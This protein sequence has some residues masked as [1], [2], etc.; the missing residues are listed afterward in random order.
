MS[1]VCCER[2]QLEQVIFLHYNCITSA[3]HN[4]SLQLT[5]LSFNIQLVKMKSIFVLLLSIA[6]VAAFVVQPKVNRGA[7]SLSMIMSDA[8]ANLDQSSMVSS[9][10]PTMNYLEQQKA[11][12][13][14]QYLT[15]TSSIL[16]SSSNMLSLKERPPPPT[17]EEI[18]AKKR[19]FNFWF[20]G[21]GFVAPFL[22]TFY[23]FGLRFWER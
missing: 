18:A 15:S 12:S 19:N 22:A 3:L 21:G 9:N 8:P 10:N 23:Y 17:A 11:S 4:C 1:K 5:K 16:D 6:P 2:K 13:V 7:S 20:W 14:N